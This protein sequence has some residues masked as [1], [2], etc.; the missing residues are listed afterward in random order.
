MLH[1]EQRRDDPEYREQLRLPF[2]GQ[3]KI[4]YEPPSLENPYGCLPVSREGRQ[5]YHACSLCA[6][7]CSAAW[8]A[9]SASNLRDRRI[10]STQSWK[11][12]AS[13]VTRLSRGPSL[14]LPSA[15][16]LSSVTWPR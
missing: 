1:E 3:A 10:I 13:V 7:L 11:A 5:K 15:S 14:S 2:F 6:C 9:S 12:W 16:K 4:H 8:A